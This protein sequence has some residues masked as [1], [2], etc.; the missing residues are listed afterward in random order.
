MIMKVYF[1][2]ILMGNVFARGPHRTKDFKNGSW[3]L[4]A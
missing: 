1:L 3:N 4:L 2:T